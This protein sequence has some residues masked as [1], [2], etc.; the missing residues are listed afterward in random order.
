MNA[1]EIFDDIEKTAAGNTAIDYDKKSVAIRKSAILTALE[2]VQK[3]FEA[4]AGMLEEMDETDMAKSYRDRAEEV[5]NFVT[6]K[7]ENNEQQ[8]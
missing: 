7:S 6:N 4:Q 2:A 1:Y 5:N 8:K 3:E